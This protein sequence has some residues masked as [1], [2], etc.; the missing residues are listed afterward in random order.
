MTGIMHLES[1]MI[2]CEEV[3]ASNFSPVVE[4]SRT[5]EME[6]CSAAVSEASV[7]FNH[8]EFGSQRHQQQQDFRV[9]S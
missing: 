9:K 7:S 5:K 1:R 6:A 4:D 8:D 3:E 2:S